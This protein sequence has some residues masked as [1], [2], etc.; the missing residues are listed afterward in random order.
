VRETKF[1]VWDKKSRKMDKALLIG[2]NV[3]NLANGGWRNRDDVEVMQFTGLRD[4]TGKEIYEGDIVVLEHIW[5]G[6]TYTEVPLRTVV[7]ELIPNCINL[8]NDTLKVIGNIYENPVEITV[9]SV[10]NS[11]PRFDG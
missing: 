1:R 6:Y 3:L 8:K 4:A 9:R 11:R 2:E 10:E 5:S 7:V